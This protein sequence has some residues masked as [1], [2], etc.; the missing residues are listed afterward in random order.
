[1]AQQIEEQICG[2]CGEVGHLAILCPKKPKD[3]RNWNDIMEE[4]A[5]EYKRSTLVDQSI[6]SARPPVQV[7]MYKSLLAIRVLREDGNY[8]IGNAVALGDWVVTN[9]HT[10]RGA[11]ATAQINATPDVLPERW[12]NLALHPLANHVSG[13]LLDC[14][15][16][17]A[18]FPKT[19]LSN[20]L[21]LATTN[22]LKVGENLTFFAWDFPMVAGG[23]MKMIT[24]NSNYFGDSDSNMFATEDGTLKEFKGLGIVKCTTMDGNS[25]GIFVKGNAVAGILKGCENKLEGNA[26]FIHCR[27]MNLTKRK[28]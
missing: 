11:K 19:G 28:N 7:Q 20:V 2:F 9:A 27:Y 5:H 4:E 13:G 10:L 18:Y 3:T 15:L 22:E 16:D 21:S 14:D 17:V 8:N 6:V 24:N 12:C 26:F 23:K 25:G 1:V